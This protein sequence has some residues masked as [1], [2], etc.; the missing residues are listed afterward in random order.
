[1]PSVNGLEF[2]KRVRAHPSLGKT[3]FIMVTAERMD[4][5]MLQAIEQG[6]TNYITKPYGARTLDEKIRKSLSRG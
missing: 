4:I 5:N 2:L 3:P 1:M 6:V